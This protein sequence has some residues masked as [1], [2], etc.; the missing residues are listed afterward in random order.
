[1]VRKLFLF[2][3][4]VASVSSRS[5]GQSDRDIGVGIQ[6]GSPTGLTV[7]LHADDRTSYD[8][9]AAWDLD[10]FFFVNAHFLWERRVEEGVDQD[11]RMFYG[12]GAFIGFFDRNAGD[13]AGLGV[14]GTAGAA[15]WFGA[16]ELYIQITPRFSLI[17]DTDFA[18]GG[19]LG[20]RLY[21]R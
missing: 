11:L 21:F 16:V 12:P 15:M 7:K 5:Y 13:E 14:S 18:I 8:F 10:D 17:P 6:L 9:L 2:A 3:L 20:A 4:V 1:M 19:G